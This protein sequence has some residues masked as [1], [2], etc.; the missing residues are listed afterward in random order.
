MSGPEAQNQSQPLGRDFYDRDSREVAVDLLGCVLVS[1]SAEGLTSGVVVETEAY[2]PDDPACHAYENR[3]T[4]RNRTIFSPPGFAYVYLSYGVHRLLNV[5]CEPE[6][7]GSAILIRALRPVEGLDL[8]QSRR[9][10]SDLCTGPGK[11]TRA[12]GVDLDLDGHDTER[13]P[14]YILRGA[15]P[16]AA[17]LATT[18]I[19][20]TRGADLP[21]RYI[22]EGEPNVSVKPAPE[23][24]PLTRGAGRLF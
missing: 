19:G 18:R 23:A 11:L 2:R 13:S 21:W 14:L 10:K 22:L 5:V 20:I 15:P 12:L 8:M 24:E 9:G 4:M 6:G 7:V 16:E 17:I 3:G 1:E